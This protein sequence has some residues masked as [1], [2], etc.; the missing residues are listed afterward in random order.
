MIL[1][2]WRNFAK[3]GHTACYHDS[4]AFY[5]ARLNGPFPTNVDDANKI[6]SKLNYRP[7]ESPSLFFIGLNA[8][9]FSL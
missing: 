1:P 6:I 5:T 7:I 3:S 4:T 8:I 9:C 2:K